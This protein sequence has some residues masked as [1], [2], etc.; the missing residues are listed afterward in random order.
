M[1]VQLPML[2]LTTLRPT[3]IRSYHSAVR[4]PL[5]VSTT[6][7]AALVISASAFA[8]PADRENSKVPEPDCST[9]IG[10]APV[11]PAEVP[12]KKIRLALHVFQKDDGADN[13]QDTPEHREYL[14]LVIA[15]ANKR[16]RAL[17]RLNMGTSPYL[18]DARVEVV[19]QHIYYHPHTAD[20][21]IPNADT[22]YARYVVR[23]AD[24]LGLTEDTK[25]NVQHVLLKGSTSPGRGGRASGIGSQG[26]ILIRGWYPH[27]LENGPTSHTWGIYNHFIHEL[28]H[29]LGLSHNFMGKH[30]GCDVCPDNDLPEK[31]CPP[32]GTS[33][34]FQDYPPLGYDAPDPGFSECQLG[35][36]HYFLSGQA[37]TIHRVVVPDHCSYQAEETMTITAP[38][39]IWTDRKMLK[40]DLI[41]EA[42]A[43]LTVKCDVH[44][45]HGGAV[46]VRPGGRL[47]VDG[48]SFTNLCG[49][50]WSGIELWGVAPPKETPKKKAKGPLRDASM[51]GQLE[52][53]N[54]GAIEHAPCAVSTLR[55]PME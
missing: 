37:G 33:T 43:T 20:W 19:L 50:T 21:D 5:R 17:G 6:I 35:R 3:R 46:L 30:G 54:G 55:P 39:R 36:I 15:A 18:S 32:V 31:K 52:L 23:D 7:L 14:R 49:D 11:H 2:L 9:S 22:A 1:P 34:N 42:G 51:Q 44:I 41:I 29:S 8:Q 26:W 40:G 38:D 27:Y 24:S 45:P 25:Y 53:R 12:I 10:Y 47:I 48:G 16:F 28:T 4:R 13:F